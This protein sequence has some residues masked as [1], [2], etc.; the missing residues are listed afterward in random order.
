M[1]YPKVEGI[2]QAK[3]MVAASDAGVTLLETVIAMFVL[4]IFAVGVLPILT[5]SLLQSVNNS[6]LVTAT[7]L[8]SQAIEDAKAQTSCSALTALNQTVTARPNVILRTVRTI[9][10][11]PTTFPST[12]K[13]SV[14]VSN[15]K[16]GAV[17]VSLGTL[18][19]VSGA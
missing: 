10:V 8:A 1:N 2:T 16:T 11:C 7:S 4:M 3:R 15:A 13:V 6:E 18:V 17:E 9:A 12:V 5:Q 19:F 14:T